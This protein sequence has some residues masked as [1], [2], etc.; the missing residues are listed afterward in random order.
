[1]EFP[2]S[3]G[4]QKTG[5]PLIISSDNLCFLIDT[6]STHNT[7][8]GFVYEHFKDR[9]KMLEERRNIIG[10]DG[11]Q[12][13]APT[14]EATFNIINPIGLTNYLTEQSVSVNDIFYKTSIDKLYIIPSGPIP[15]NPSELIGSKKM[16]KLIKMLEDA[17]D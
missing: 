3:L 2:L 7:L 8:F 10:I 4:L 16:E 5:L 13:K 15:P 14:I 1:M 6:G 11:V 9:F 17:F 12:H